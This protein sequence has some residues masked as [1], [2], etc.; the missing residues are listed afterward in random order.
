MIN[1]QGQIAHGNA[2]ERTVRIWE[3]KRAAWLAADSDAE[4]NRAALLAADSDAERTRA[5]RG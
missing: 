4:R 2:S 3:R 5:A 1:A